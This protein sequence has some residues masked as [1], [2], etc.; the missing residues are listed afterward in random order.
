MRKSPRKSPRHS[1]RKSPRSAGSRRLTHGQR[2]AA[3]KKGWRTRRMHSR[4][5]SPRRARRVASPRGRKVRVYNVHARDRTYSHPHRLT[6]TGRAHK[7]DISLVDYG[8]HRVR[9]RAPHVIAL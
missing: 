4:A 9:S 8:V 7:K 2:S 3:A 1:P 5:A 6:T